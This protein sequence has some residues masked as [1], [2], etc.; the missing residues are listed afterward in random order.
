MRASLPDL[1]EDPPDAWGADHADELLSLVIAGTKTGTAMSLWECEMT[2][3]AI[4]PLG[5]YSIILDGSGRPAA[6]IQT[7]RIDT[8][9]FGDV[10]ADHAHAEGEDDRTLATWRNIHEQYWRTHSPT[11]FAWD[12]PVVC[13]RFIH[14]APLAFESHR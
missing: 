2:G 11:G 10:D 9:P 1:L 4:P 13:E 6:I 12:M 8:V 5:D 7:T 3:E 14:P